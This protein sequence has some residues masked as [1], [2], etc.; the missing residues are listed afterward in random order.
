MTVRGARGPCAKPAKVRRRILESCAEAF[1]ETGFYGAVM[2]DVAG[3]AGISLTG[4]LHHFPHKEDLLRAVPE[5]RA[6]RGREM[7]ERAGALDPVG[8]PLRVLR[9]ML[10]LITD[11][12]ARPGLV[13][14]HCVMSGEAASPSHPAHG[15]YADRFRGLRHFC[16]TAFASLARRGELRS[17]LPPEVLADM[18]LSLLNGPRTQWLYDRDA[19]DVEGGVRAF[20]ISVVPA[21]AD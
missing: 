15:Y 2:K 14:L 17:T 13:E 1:A 10:D 21:L 8:A 12:A 7:L 16:A 19:V 4:L 5:F 11:N 20:L 9:G 18:T 6:E 3:R